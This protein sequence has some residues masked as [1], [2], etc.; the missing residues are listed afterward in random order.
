MCR[1]DVD[2][3]QG[4]PNDLTTDVVA[5]K[6]LRRDC[7]DATRADFE[8]EARILT[9]LRDLNLV[10]VLGVGYQDDGDEG[11][12][13]KLP[14]CMVCEYLREDLCPFLQDH[15][16]ETTLSKSPNVPTLRYI[17]CIFTWCSSDDA[18]M[19]SCLQLWM[20][21]FYRLSDRFGNEIFG[22]SQFCP[23]GSGLQ[24]LLSGPPK[25]N[26]DMRFWHEPFHLQK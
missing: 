1:L 22:V 6:Y 19:L 20:P 4:L 24:K 18:I 10:R 15:V 25:P 3:A 11:V 16:A 23:S 12:V 17:E 13:A 21:H 7:D 26:Q 9:S 8:H 14:F 5:V 2:Q